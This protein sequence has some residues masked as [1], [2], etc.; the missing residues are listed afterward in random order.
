MLLIAACLS[1]TPDLQP[2]TDPGLPDTPG[3][4]PTLESL[5]A[6]YGTPEAWDPV[7]AAL[8]APHQHETY[9]AIANDCQQFP[10]DLFDS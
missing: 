6:R 7:S 8:A 3:P 10:D 2:G 1:R 9:V 4:P 5:L